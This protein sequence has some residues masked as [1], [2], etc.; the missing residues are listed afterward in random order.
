MENN[1]A[2]S[3]MINLEDY[4]KKIEIEINEVIKDSNYSELS[5]Y[6]H[7]LPNEYGSDESLY[8]WGVS[9][10]NEYFKIIDKLDKIENSKIEDL[11]YKIYILYLKEN[12]SDFVFSYNEFITFSRLLNVTFSNYN[13]NK[14][15]ENDKKTY[16][17]GDEEIDYIVNK[18]VNT[19]NHMPR[20]HA[21]EIT[22]FRLKILLDVLIDKRRT[23]LKEE[24]DK[25]DLD[26]TLLIDNLSE[27]RI[28][29]LKKKKN[30]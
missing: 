17:S 26:D 15:R 30:H 12:Y 4:T 3:K 29:E 13:P 11:K 19:V 20:P 28:K 16:K 6:L 24:F 18:V 7:M 8:Y 10:I 21:Y 27:D 14:K 5:K 25:I 2:D 1:P 9:Y 22:K 23:L